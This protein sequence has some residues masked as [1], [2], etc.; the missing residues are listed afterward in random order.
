M[1]KAILSVV[2]IPHQ[3]AEK[4]HSL[5][6]DLLNMIANHSVVFITKNLF[7]QYLSDHG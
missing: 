3:A 7:S 1:L 4:S 6:F 5:T 2:Y